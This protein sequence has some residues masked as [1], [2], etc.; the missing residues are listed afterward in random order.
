MW[1]TAVIVASLGSWIKVIMNL[2]SGS[3]FGF[4]LLVFIVF[5]EGWQVFYMVLFRVLFEYILSIFAVGGRFI[6]V[7]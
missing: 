3:A 5:T 1:A 6:L 7:F 4:S 2:C